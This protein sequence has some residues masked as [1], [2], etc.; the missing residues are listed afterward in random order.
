[1]FSA[2]RTRPSPL[3]TPQRAFD[4][5]QKRD[6]IGKDTLYINWGLWSDGTPDIDSAARALVLYIG[7]LAG[8]GP[9]ARLLDVG[10]GYGDQ[11]LDWCRLAHLGCAEGLNICPEQ[12]AIARARLV[13]AGL[14]GRVNVQVGDAVSL[15][16][17]RDEFTAVTAVECAFHFRTREQF[18]RE[19]ARVLRPGGSLV[20]ADFIDV[21]KPGLRTKLAQALTA[22]HWNFAPD[23]FCSEA[24]YRAML[25]ESGLAVRS[26]ERLTD[27]VIPPGMIYAR[28]R[29]WEQD[30]RTRMRRW[31]WLTTV[32]AL[33]VSRMLGDPLPGEYIL[34]RAEKP[35]AR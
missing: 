24:R 27:R 29:V 21:D 14:A 9:D 35:L 23:S 3:P 31:T 22:R 2:T 8:L 11:L 33:G 4:V 6:L 30:L 20:L 18:F 7:E 12:T 19:A 34:V 16:F 32:A 25:E 17:Q 28:T 26:I 5:Y 15:P 13:D 10:F 1:M